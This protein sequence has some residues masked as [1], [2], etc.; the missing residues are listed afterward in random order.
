MSSDRES[1]LE[2]IFADALNRVPE[3]RGVFLD[4]ECGLD[5]DLRRRVDSLLEHSGLSSNS[6]LDAVEA[7]KAAV[8]AQMRASGDS[9]YLRCGN[10]RRQTALL[11]HGICR[12]PADRRALR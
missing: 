11:C 8:E 1:R 3:E 4:R 9:T 2:S 5:S 6:F 12:G 10:D 7:A